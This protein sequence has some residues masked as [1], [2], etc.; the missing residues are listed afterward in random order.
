MR[1]QNVSQIHLEVS[2]DPQVTALLVL[3]AYLISKLVF[4]AFY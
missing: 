4:A 2:E 1:V 3:S